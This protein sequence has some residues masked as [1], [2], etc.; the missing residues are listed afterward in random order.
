MGYCG[1]EHE[2]E[3]WEVGNNLPAFLPWLQ[4]LFTETEG[5]GGKAVLGEGPWGRPVR[6]WT[7]GA[8]F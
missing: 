7:G 2:G 8:E 4:L 5:T 3:G 6:F 1:G